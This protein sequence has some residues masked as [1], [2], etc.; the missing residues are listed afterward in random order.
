[1]KNTI[2]IDTQY[3][4]NYNVGPEGFNQYGD[5]MPHWK[6]KGGHQFKIELDTDFVMYGDANA[7]FA[8]MVESHNSIAEKFEYIGYE[9]QWQE[10][11]VLGS[12]EDFI[13]FSQELEAEEAP[14][15]IIAG[16]DFTDSINALNDLSI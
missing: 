8:K 6:P 1:M 3:Y 2:I 15:H 12:E 16:V 10:P 9:I 13:K 4:E 14:S 7:I 11:T 5:K